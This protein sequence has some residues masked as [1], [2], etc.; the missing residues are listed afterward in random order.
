MA[1]CGATSDNGLNSP[2]DVRGR[3]ATEMA[4]ERWTAAIARIA[5]ANLPPP[6]VR[7]GGVV[8]SLCVGAGGARSGPS[9]LVQRFTAPVSQVAFSARFNVAAPTRVEIAWRSEDDVIQR[10]AAV[11]VPGSHLVGSLSSRSGSLPLG[12]YFVEIL[13][14]GNLEARAEFVI[15]PPDPPQ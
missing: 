4:I 11:V 6:W 2:A 13:A 3:P 8:A 15:V 1:V 14:G 12:R 10:S 9:S 5:E 7:A